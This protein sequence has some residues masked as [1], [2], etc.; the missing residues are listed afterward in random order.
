MGTYTIDPAH[1]EVGFVARH[2]VGT[3]VRGRFTEVEGTFTVAENPEDSTLEATVQAASI[4][5]SQSQRDDHLRTND[6]L[7][8]PNHPTLT[9]VGTGLRRVD[10]TNWVLGADLTIRGVTKPVDFDLEFLGEGASMQEGKTVVAFSA[11]A[12]IDRRTSA[13]AS[14]TRCSTAASWWAT[15]SSSRSRPRPPWPSRPRPRS[16]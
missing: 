4:H 6:F 8:V 7:D 5:T 9:L 15:R 3:K 13:S 16:T 12:T 11:T 1:T 14:T 10:D 2:L